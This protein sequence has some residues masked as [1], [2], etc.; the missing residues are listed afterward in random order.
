[1]VINSEQTPK[2][3]AEAPT[4]LVLV[5]GRVYFGLTV[6]E[7]ERVH[8]HHAEGLHLVHRQGAESL[9]SLGDQ[10]SCSL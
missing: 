8:H 2:Q 9:A 4:L 3:E 6:P 1:M 7:G 5:Q 10:V